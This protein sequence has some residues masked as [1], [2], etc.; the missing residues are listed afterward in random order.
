MCV[1]QKRVEPQLFSVRKGSCGLKV[2]TVYL[3]HCTRRPLLF[4]VY[5]DVTSSRSV[6]SLDKPQILFLCAD[7]FIFSAFS[8]DL[9]FYCSSVFCPAN[10]AVVYM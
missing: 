1:T 8:R 5:M 7:V 10:E 6:I 3:G 4:S 9:I 2:T